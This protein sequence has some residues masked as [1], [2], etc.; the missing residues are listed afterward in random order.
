ME[1]L[2]GMLFKSPWFWMLATFGSGWAILRQLETMQRAQAD[3]ADAIEGA[4][5]E[6]DGD[7]CCDDGYYYEDSGGYDGGGDGGGG[8]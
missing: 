5:S 8:E 6:R 2:F 4:A 3:H 1:F 7:G